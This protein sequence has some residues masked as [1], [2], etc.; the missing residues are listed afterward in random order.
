MRSAGA[1]LATL[2]VCTSACAPA[3]VGCTAI[4]SPSGIAVKVDR[5]LAAEVTK[6][7]L[8]VC[9][10]RTCRDRDIDLSPGAEAHDQGC[11]GSDPESACS[12]T[13]VPNGTKVGFAVVEDL[14]AATI[15]VG[16]VITQAAHV[17]RLAAI[18]LSATATYPNGRDCGAGGN[19]AQ[20]TVG[21]D[22]LH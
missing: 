9:W 4:G 10:D 5:A 19:Q 11:A 13:M 7:D 21:R 3:E 2:V 14:P 18:D 6:I 22:G 1:L 16:A 20:I 8:R 12:A 17:R 15:T